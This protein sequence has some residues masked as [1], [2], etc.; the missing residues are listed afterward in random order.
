MLGF[1][2]AMFLSFLAKL[3]ILNIISYEPKQA[4]L[5]SFRMVVSAELRVQ[6][7][8]GAINDH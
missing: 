2:L 6:H 8:T 5:A 7:G 1:C 4:Q 3:V